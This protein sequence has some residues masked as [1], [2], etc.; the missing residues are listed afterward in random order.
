[1]LKFYNPLPLLA[2]LQTS[3][4]NLSITQDYRKRGRYFDTLWLDSIIITSPPPV[5]FT[6]LLKIEIL[7]KKKDQSKFYSIYTESDV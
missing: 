7:K 2:A 3:D 1:M 5:V 4:E 6:S